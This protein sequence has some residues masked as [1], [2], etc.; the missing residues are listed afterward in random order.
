MESAAT[1]QDIRRRMKSLEGGFAVSGGDAAETPAIWRAVEASEAF[2][3]ARRILI[4]MDIPG[5]VPTAAFIRK[6]VSDKKFLLPLV[7]G[8][9]LDLYEYDPAHLKHGYRG[10]MEPDGMTP[11]VSPEDVELALVPGVAFSSAV[12]GTSFPE[13]VTMPCWRMGRGR[14]FYDRL[15]P[16]LACRCFGIGFSFRWLP[17]I[18][19]DPWDAPLK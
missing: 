11:L 15:I 8:E 5:E 2:R 19:L 4:Y 14:G 6:W 9:R 7:V 18:P 16:G 1:K 13:C 12:P 10:I 3:T 17:S